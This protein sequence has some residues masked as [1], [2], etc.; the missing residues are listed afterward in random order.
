MKS[1]IKR[2]NLL[3]NEVI[4]ESD[5]PSCGVFLLKQMIFELLLIIKIRGH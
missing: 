3:I 4:D 1:S 2:F 5:W